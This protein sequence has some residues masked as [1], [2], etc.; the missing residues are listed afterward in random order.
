MIASPLTLRNYFVEKLT[1]SANP[2]FEPDKVVS[3]EL[4]D[5]R[6]ESLL[7]EVGEG[8]ASVWQV[9]LRLVQNVPAERN[10][11]YNFSVVLIGFFEVAPEYPEDRRR[12]LVETNARSIL[13]GTCREIVRATTAQGP[14]GPML[15]PSV[16]F[17]EPKPAADSTTSPG[18]GPSAKQGD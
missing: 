4:D 12:R 11:P 6:I 5:I 8:D 16:S 3:L 7:R 13:Y 18:E 15:L 14:Y 17:Y 2:E 1:F 10:A 9:N